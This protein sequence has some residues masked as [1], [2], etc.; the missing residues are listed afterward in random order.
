M[1]VVF[2]TMSLMLC[3]FNLLINNIMIIGGCCQ[4]PLSGIRINIYNIQMRHFFRVTL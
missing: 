1:K 2:Q 4:A 3:S